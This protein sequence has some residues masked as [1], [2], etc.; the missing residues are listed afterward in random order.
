MSYIDREWDFAS[1]IAYLYNAFSGFSDGEITTEERKEQSV[2]LSKWL[3]GGKYLDEKG[4]GYDLSNDEI[5]TLMDKTLNWF[6]IDIN[7]KGEDTVREACMCVAK[8]HRKHFSLHEHITLVND[9]IRIALADNNF[10]E[11][12][13][14]WIREMASILGL[15]FSNLENWETE[16]MKLLDDRHK[17]YYSNGQ[18]KEEGNYK[19]GEK[20]GIWTY[21]YKNGK[22]EWEETYDHG[23]LKKSVGW[24]ENG[25][26]AEEG[27]FKNALPFGEWIW[28]YNN[29]K[30]DAQG[31]FKIN[32]LKDGIWTEWYV[33]GRKKKEGNY[34]N[35]D[36]VG[37]WT[38]YN[39]D[40]SV[41][42]VKE[43]KN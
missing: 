17:D 35:G 26:K 36:Q 33:N 28:W 14:V 12:E 5:S 21:W 41:K 32:R 31:T 10:H 30:K 42:L 3:T 6:Y 9:L 40:G 11:N 1:S 38:I 18:L 7:K 16:K 25:I 34:K 8:V 29:G 22:K 23:K 20:V 4:F 27:E 15:N 37:K 43:Y 39:E 24:Y 2:C 13:K 19:D